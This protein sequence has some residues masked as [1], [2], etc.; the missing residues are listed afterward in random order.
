MPFIP[1]LIAVAALAP[2]LPLAR[3]DEAP[4]PTTAQPPVGEPAPAPS[5]P[6]ASEPAPAPRVTGSVYFTTGVATSPIDGIPDGFDRAAYDLPVIA[7]ANVT[8]HGQRAPLDVWGDL[9][10][11]SQ[12]YGFD[13]LWGGA[14]GLG[15]HSTVGDGLFEF[16]VGFALED[17]ASLK[18]APVGG[19]YLDIWRWGFLGKAQYTTGI[20]QPFAALKWW[21]TPTVTIADYEGTTTD[22]AWDDTYALTLGL[23]I[24]LPLSLLAE[25][26]F[27]AYSLGAVAIGSKEFA[28]FIGQQ[29]VYQPGI[30]MGA[31]LG[32]WEAWLRYS[33][34]Y[35]GRNDDATE[36]LY[37]TPAYYNDNLMVRDRITA[38]V[39]WNF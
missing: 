14:F 5:Q 21:N 2:P 36:Y 35:P 38:E 1:I 7:G 31:E 27:S 37:Q 13:P 16:T 15:Y 34:A 23:R 33:R 39:R 22:V 12:T 6:A 24:R 3:A 4:A 19:S 25:A 10:G 9:H 30:G 11:G 29:P 17:Q 26:S 28:Y 32:R 8:F 18:A 20:Y